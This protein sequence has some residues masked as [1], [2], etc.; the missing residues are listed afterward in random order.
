MK[1]GVP[2]VRVRR[3]GYSVAD[4]PISLTYCDFSPDRY[5]REVDQVSDKPR[6]LGRGRIAWTA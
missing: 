1:A 4:M 6:R 5:T 2:L 3:I